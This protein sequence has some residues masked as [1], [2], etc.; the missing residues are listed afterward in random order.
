MP[1][2][3]GRSVAIAHRLVMKAGRGR[4]AYRSALWPGRV[5]R[6]AAGGF[7]RYAGLARLFVVTGV[8]PVRA[9]RRETCRSLALRCSPT[10]SSRLV[11]RPGHVEHGQRP[12]VGAVVLQD[13]AHL[14]TLARDRDVGRVVQVAGEVAHR[15]VGLTVVLY[16]PRHERMLRAH[17][18][19]PA[20]SRRPSRFRSSSG[21]SPAFRA[22]QTAR[23]SRAAVRTACA[24]CC[25]SGVP[26]RQAPPCRPTAGGT[27]MTGSN[28]AATLKAEMKP[29]VR[30]AGVTECRGARGAAGRGGSDVTV[31][32]ATCC[33]RSRNSSRY[34]SGQ[35]RL[36]CPW[37]PQTLQWPAPGETSQVRMSWP[38]VPHRE[39]VRLPLALIVAS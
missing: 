5:G 17:S 11:H 22:S 9:W 8:P 38:S 2:T 32:G 12:G 26:S 29:A 16:E 30:S 15:R 14:G 36:S 6:S 23:S 34:L 7:C 21:R 31:P 1:A 33:A 20:R 13:L 19:P 35:L 4:A 10:A 27:V 18:A 39:Q 28:M 25:V 24:L 3:S 37:K